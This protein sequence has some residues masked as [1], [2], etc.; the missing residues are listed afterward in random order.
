MAD[1]STTSSN[2]PSQQQQGKSTTNRL[3]DG[4]VNSKHGNII[5]RTT[6]ESLRLAGSDLMTGTATAL[7]PSSSPSLLI[8]AANSSAQSSRNKSKNSSFQIT[9]VTVG[10]RMSADN[11]D[12]SADDLDESH[13]DDNSRITD[14]E[15]ETPSFSEDTFSKE[16]VFFSSSGI[17]TAPVIPTSSQYGLAIVAPDPNGT[18]SQSI[19]DVHVSVTDAGINIMGGPNKHDVDLKDMHNRNERFKVVKIEST[20]PFKRGR[21]MCMDY[22]DHTTLQQSTSTSETSAAKDGTADSGIVINENEHDNTNEDSPNK[23]VRTE[24]NVH[25]LIHANLMAGQSAPGGGYPSSASTSPGQTLSHP[26]PSASETNEHVVTSHAQTMSHV[27]VNE[28]AVPNMVAAAAPAQ[29]L[30]PQQ[31]QQILTQV[32][33]SSDPAHLPGSNQTES[34][35][36]QPIAEIQQQQQQHQQSSQQQHQQPQQHHNAMQGQ[37]QPAHFY[38]SNLE[39]TNHCQ[40]QTLPAGT[41]QNIIQQG[42]QPHP[43]QVPLVVNVSSVQDHSSIQSNNDTIVNTATDSSQNQALF[44]QQS[45]INNQQPQP[46]VSSIANSQENSSSPS[47]YPMSNNSNQSVGQSAPMLASIGAQLSQLQQQHQQQQSNQQQPPVSMS[48]AGDTAQPQPTQQQPLASTAFVQPIIQQ[49]SNFDPSSSASTGSNNPNLVITSSVPSTSSTIVP[50]NVDESINN[51]QSGQ[52]TAVPPLS[53]AMVTTALSG[54][55]GGSTEQPPPQLTT[56]QLSEG[57][58]AASTSSSSSGNSSVPATTA[59]GD[60]STQPTEENERYEFVHFF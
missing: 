14:L 17:G 19:S 54:S 21:W 36:M 20:E 37:S 18:G 59:T 25:S 46:A 27:P 16:D 45:N 28:T 40:G 42:G 1:G 12:D 56:E 22:L 13:T 3:C 34:Q 9:S 5:H 8:N 11:G 23:T 4:K 48:V 15:N 57:G 7:P 52:V 30:P 58:A 41:L 49:Q 51:V 32:S 50:P 60:E 31:L 43:V 33:N 2:F 39:Q 35:T 26:L 24:I 47:N 53:P 6:S 10:P 55:G 38:S 29:S 44:Q